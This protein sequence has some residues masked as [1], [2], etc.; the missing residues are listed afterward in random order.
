M[1]EVSRLVS[2]TYGEVAVSDI[3]WR[4]I[5]FKSEPD[6]PIEK[7]IFVTMQSWRNWNDSV[8]YSERIST[9]FGGG[10]TSNFKT[11]RRTRND[12]GTR[13]A[14]TEEISGSHCFWAWIM[15]TLIPRRNTTRRDEVILQHDMEDSSKDILGRVDVGSPIP[16][17]IF[18]RHCFLEPGIWCH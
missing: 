14:H 13:K 2:D 12:L 9:I 8:L 1:T 10:S 15:N 18:F 5:I 11:P 4:T 3:T 7:K 6:K 16:W 17:V